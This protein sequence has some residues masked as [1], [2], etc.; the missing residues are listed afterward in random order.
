M[1]LDDNTDSVFLF[2]YGT[3]LKNHKSQYHT[4]FAKNWKWFSSGYLYGKLYE[5][6][7]YPGAILSENSKD[8]VFGEIYAIPDAEETFILLDIYEGCS[9]NSPE[10][11]EYRRSQIPIYIEKKPFLIAWTYLY[12]GDTSQLKHLPSGNYLD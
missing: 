8:R 9:E 2:V 11:H 7:G 1:T 3:L 12:I 5:I 10:P 6:D 4:Q